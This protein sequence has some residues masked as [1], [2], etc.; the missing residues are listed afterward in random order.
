MLD[1]MKKTKQNNNASQL[2][3]GRIKIHI[4]VYHMDT[5]AEKYRLESYFCVTMV[6]TH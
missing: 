1:G 2:T 5:N 3:R 6:S 4:S